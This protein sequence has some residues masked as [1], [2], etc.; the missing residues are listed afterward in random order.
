MQFAP[1]T[2]KPGCGS[3]HA[4]FKTVVENHWLRGECLQT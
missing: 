4:A 3:A 1:Q 2:S